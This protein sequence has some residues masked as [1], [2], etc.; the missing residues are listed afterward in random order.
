[1]LFYFCEYLIAL[2]RTR[3]CHKFTVSKFSRFNNVFG[4]FAA[5]PVLKSK[6]VTIRHRPPPAP[7]EKGS[8][9]GAVSADDHLNKVLAKVNEYDTQVREVLY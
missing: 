9:K 1:M 4:K 3:A 8:R 5:G 6:G 7:S 2:L